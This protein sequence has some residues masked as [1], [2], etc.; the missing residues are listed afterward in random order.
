MADE[1]RESNANDAKH[2]QLEDFEPYSSQWLNTVAHRLL[3]GDNL[4]EVTETIREVTHTKVEAH[5]RA[6]R[7]QAWQRFGLLLVALG[8]FGG[9]GW[10]YRNDPEIVRLL[11]VSFVSFLGGSVLGSRASR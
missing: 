4:K 2:E 1:L 6:I 8:M 5:A 3:E 7:R 10:L 9:A 11:I